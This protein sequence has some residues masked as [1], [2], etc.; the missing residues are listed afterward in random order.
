MRGSAFCL[1]R[2]GESNSRTSCMPC[3]FRTVRAISIRRVSLTA[4][5]LCPARSAY[6]TRGLSS[7]PVVPVRGSVHHRPV[8]P[9]VESDAAGYVAGY[10]FYQFRPC[11]TAR[12]L[13]PSS[14]IA[15]VAASVATAVATLEATSIGPLSRPVERARLA[16]GY[17]PSLDPGFGLEH[18]AAHGVALGIPWISGL[19]T[20]SWR[21]LRARAVVLRTD[22]FHA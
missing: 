2:R 3:S 13:L 9:G 17:E 8:S 18:S 10:V 14:E 20:T 6:R 21:D 16:L 11:P 12:I 7:D 1:W 5:V 22:P 19:E 4:V 15:D